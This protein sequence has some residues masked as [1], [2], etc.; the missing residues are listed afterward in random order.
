MGATRCAPRTSR[1]RPPRSSAPSP[2]QNARCPPSPCPA[3]GCRPWRRRPPWLG[4]WLRSLRGPQR[5]W[6]SPRCTTGAPMGKS[7][8][9]SRHVAQHMTRGRDCGP[10][11]SSRPSE[12]SNASSYWSLRS[13]VCRCDPYGTVSAENAVWGAAAALRSLVPPECGSRG[14]LIGLE[15]VPSHHA[16]P[17]HRCARSCRRRSHP[18]P[19]NAS[20]GELAARLHRVSGGSNRESG[21][22]GL[23]THPVGARRQARRLAF[24]T[25]REPTISTGG[26]GGGEA[27]SIELPRTMTG[28]R[29]GWT[30]DNCLACLH[31]HAI[32]TDGAVS[33]KRGG[34]SPLHRAAAGME[35]H[36]GRPHLPSRDHGQRW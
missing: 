29:R 25:L 2:R 16:C 8:S 18:T 35:R 24:R 6:A 31:R 13:C 23:A 30:V 4:A 20:T 7:G 34:W 3:S 1:P 26:A 19:G 12:S 5:P 17:P 14:G 36:H 27:A 21:R 22:V 9:E 11:L 15:R 33:C 28:P 32:V 10:H